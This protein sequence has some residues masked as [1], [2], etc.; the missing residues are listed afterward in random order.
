MEQFGCMTVASGSDPKDIKIYGNV[1]YNST[2]LGGL[3]ST[4]T[5]AIRLSLQVYNNTFYNAPVVINNNGANVTQFQFKNNI[6]Y[7]SSGVPL[8]DAEASNHV[9]F[10]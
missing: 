5:S 7:S 4:R 8:T 9:P 2:A 10:Q 1:V 6:V 3:L